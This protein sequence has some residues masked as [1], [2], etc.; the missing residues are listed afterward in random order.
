MG[1][2]VVAALVSAILS[3]AA[4]C[5]LVIAMNITNDIYKPFIAPGKS[6]AHYL[7]AN[8]ILLFVAG[9]LA[10]ITVLA[11]PSVI[12]LLYMACDVMVGA[13]FFPIIGLFFWK[14]I[15]SG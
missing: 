9:V 10:L 7:K 11:I 12:H 3:T 13:L 8:R 2:V 6:N 4:A 5:F 15:N 14:R 1:A